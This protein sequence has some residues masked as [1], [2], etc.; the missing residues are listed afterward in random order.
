MK[1]RIF[2]LFLIVSM[3][4]SNYHLHAQM[5]DLDTKTLTSEPREIIDEDHPFADPDYL[6]AFLARFQR[7]SDKIV[8]GEEV[9]VLDYPWQVSLQTQPNFG[10][11]HFCGGTIIDREW[12]LTASHCLEDPAINP[13]VIRIRAGFTSLS[14]GEGSYHDISEII[15]HPQYNDNNYD[16]D[17]ALLRL[18]DPID[19]D[20][21]AT[22]SVDLVRIFD[23]EAGLTDAGV[24]SKVSGWGSLSS[25][26][27]S[28]D[29]LHAVEVPI[30]A[31][32]AGYNPSM[33]TEGMLLAG[34]A[35]KDACQGDSG[36]PL[37]VPDGNGF[38]KI[39]GVVSWGNGCGLANFPGVYAR[40]S[41]YED[42]I[43]QYIIGDDPNQYQTLWF[44]G[45]EPPNADGALPEGWEVKVNTAEDG[46]LNGNNLADTV[47]VDI[48]DLWFR[49]SDDTYPYNEGV[50]DQYIRT[51]SAAMHIFWDAADLN[52]AISPEI[53]LPDNEE[54]ALELSFWPWIGNDASQ[55]WI[56]KFYLTV[57]VNDQWQTLDSLDDG[58]DYPF[59]TD[60][61]VDLEELKGDTVR[62]G[63]VHDWNDGFQ[64]SVDDI[65]LRRENQQITAQWLITDGAD[66]LSDAFVRIRGVGQFTT[67]ET[68][69]LDVPVY[70]GD[71]EYEYSVF[72]AGYFPLEGSVLV[73]EDGQIVVVSMEKIPAPEIV[74]T[75]DALTFELAL[76]YTDST[77]LNISNPG[78]AEL[79]VSLFPYPVLADMKDVSAAEP[80]Q[81][82][83]DQKTFIDPD[84]LQA[85]RMSSGSQQMVMN[86]QKDH[87]DAPGEF[88]EIFYDNGDIT[89]S[90]RTDGAGSFAAASRFTS[91]E[92]QSYYGIYELSQVK[93][94]VA[95]D[96]FSSVEVKIWQGGSLDGPLT[97]IYAQDI[98]DEV[99]V[100]QWSTHQLPVNIPLEPGEEYWLGYAL[101]A[102]GGFPLGADTGPMVQD[103]GGWLL[104]NSNWVQ[105][106]TLGTTPLD[107]NWGIRGVL[108]MSVNI[109]WMSFN[110][111]SAVVAPETSS[112]IEILFDAT[113][114]ELGAYEAQILVVNNAGDNIAVPVS[115]NVVPPTYDVTFMITDQAGELITDAQVTLDGIENEAG[116]YLFEDME[117]GTY[118]YQI[119]KEGF[120]TSS[121]SI[122]VV[123]DHVSASVI[124]ISEE[125]T[126]VNL[127]V[128][129]KDEFDE[130]AP[131][132]EFH[133][134]GFGVKIT[135]DLGQTNFTVVPGTHAFSAMGVPFDTLSS[136][137]TVPDQE[138]VDLE[139][140]LNYV[141][142]NLGLEVNLEGTGTVTGAGE[143]YYGQSAT[144]EATAN[145]GHT[146]LHWLEDGEV[147]SEEATVNFNI[148]NEMNLM[149]V[150]ELNT[151]IITSSSEGPGAIDPEG[152]VVVEYDQDQ[153][154][155]ITPLPGAYVSDVLVNGESVGAV[156]EYIFENVTEDGNE[157]H[158]VF[159]WNSYEVT[160]TVDGS[161]TVEP[162]GTVMVE[163]GNNLAIEFAP[164][165]GHYLSD[166]L[167]NDI[168]EDP[169]E[170]FLLLEVTENTTV[171]GVFDI[172]TYMV[173]VTV[174]GNGTIS[175]DGDIEVEHGDD[176]TFELSP[177]E[178]SFVSDILVDDISVGA[179][180]EY[181]LFSIAKDT[182]LM[183]VFDLINSVTDYSDE[184]PVQV[185]PNPA[186]SSIRVKSD[187]IIDMV[188]IYNMKGQIV[189]SVNASSFEQM[190]DVEQFEAGMYFARVLSVSG[191]VSTLI[192]EVK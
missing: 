189:T 141:R 160:V 178:D 140:T 61:V 170:S 115:L 113:E 10:A 83:F 171:H 88:E 77:Q 39:A 181:T 166:L 186:F 177:G 79:E 93:Y 108:Q 14:A 1:E 159:A 34:V 126:P 45:F 173:S 105:L 98:T 42:W 55:G 31:G 114:L 137:L 111:A 187:E 33:I 172:M 97:E 146:F 54:G 74:V 64:M 138:N 147:F 36:G 165:T 13:S 20:N 68:G 69:L 99:L 124:L 143:Y 168:G 73:T 149:A 155:L 63:F 91:E 192:F 106:N 9:D 24:M 44:E 29:I 48:P 95:T 81:E 191:K 50:A 90:I 52:W 136:E 60:V 154:F 133:L 78:D 161:G 58:T 145:T 53:E 118:N 131:D 128:T 76:G 47:G 37:V 89:V 87:K 66:P 4:F 156:E 75:P 43:D 109:D 190:I 183:A 86:D 23:V 125:T 65:S 175:P 163:H 28:P 6:E 103:K 71:N 22:S 94:F 188:S 169:V 152:E 139:F 25:G 158:A 96:D 102:T 101:E 117:A 144:I 17:I 2:T 184:F 174:Q 40:V 11:Q 100:G 151:Y 7:S 182:E 92:L 51:G 134:Q 62:F 12:V 180:E 162:S 122:M 32:S 116:D 142:F 56:T 110:P 57:L 132:V 153:G 19:L 167:V 150:F 38:Y 41:Y 148:F 59:N 27:Q 104:F 35:G 46:G 130:P 112:D 3:L 8:G 107:Y 5:F 21:P 127:S 18:S 120:L 16:N 135:D 26:G 15:M 121:G 82:L 30:V 123:D 164:D 176:I 49:L 70:L 179:A 157:I 85:V 72:R 119:T 185:Y 67:D 80:G 84:Q 129:I